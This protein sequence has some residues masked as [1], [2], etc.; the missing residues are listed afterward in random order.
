MALSTF[1]GTFLLESSM[2]LGGPGRIPGD[3][4]ANPRPGHSAAIELN[5]HDRTGREERFVVMLEGVGLDRAIRLGDP[6]VWKA[7]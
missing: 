7:Q 1:P 6:E 3:L 5:M 2:R 4:R